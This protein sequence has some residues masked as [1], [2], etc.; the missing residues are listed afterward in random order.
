MAHPSK[1]Y[2]EIHWWQVSIHGVISHI[3][4]CWGMS[5]L[6]MDLHKITTNMDLFNLK[7]ARIGYPEKWLSSHIWQSST[8]SRG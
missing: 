1:T 8:E 4:L 3:C 7:A 5:F 6:Q 2:W